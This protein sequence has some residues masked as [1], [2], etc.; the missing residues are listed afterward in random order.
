MVVVVVITHPRR[1]HFSS[2]LHTNVSPSDF[3][4]SASRAEWTKFRN[5]SGVFQVAGRC[6]SS[7]GSMKFE[8]INYETGTT[9]LVGY[10]NRRPMLPL[11]SGWYSLSP[12]LHIFCVDR[13][14]IFYL[15]W[16]NISLHSFL[17][18]LPSHQLLLFP[19]PRRPQIMKAPHPH[20]ILVGTLTIQCDYVQ[21]SVMITDIN[22]L[23]G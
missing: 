5:C 12:L 4:F 1:D 10:K 6:I 23:T 7:Y 11:S 16:F 9:A 15:T 21:W 19:F 18:L 22:D 2:W 13:K 20:N 8:L 17:E 14:L 3:N